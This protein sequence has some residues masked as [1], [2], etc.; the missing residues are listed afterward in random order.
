MID[1]EALKSAIYTLAGF[2][3]ILFG[4]I[5]RLLANG[6]NRFEVNIKETVDRITVKVDKI[7]RWTADHIEK[8]HT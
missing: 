3:I 4:V 6:F 5:W 1:S 7:D 8:H 2:I